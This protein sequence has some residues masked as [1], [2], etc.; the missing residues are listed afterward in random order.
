MQIRTDKSGFVTDFALVGTLTDG[1]EVT[2][3]NDISHFEEHFASY[4]YTDKKLTFDAEQAEA[5]SLKE[6][7]EN[8]R[9]LR[10]KECFSIINR[11]QLWY[12]TLTETQRSELQAWYTA[13]LA[14]TDTLIVPDRPAWL[15]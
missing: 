15:H 3:P 7:K 8:L 9:M 12:D 4:K 10:E 6:Q 2:A 1:I 13:W 11:G 14:V 5:N